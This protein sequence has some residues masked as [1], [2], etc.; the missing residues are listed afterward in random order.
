MSHRE[1]KRVIAGLFSGQNRIKNDA[2]FR[3][4]FVRTLADI[5]IETSHLRCTCFSHEAGI[6]REKN[7]RVYWRKAPTLKTKKKVNRFFSLLTTRHMRR[8]FRP[9]LTPLHG[10]M[11]EGVFHFL[12][13]GPFSTAAG[14]TATARI[15]QFRRNLQSRSSGR[16]LKI[17]ADRPGFL[18]Q[19]L[20]DHI[21][22]A[23][24]VKGQVSIPGLIQSNP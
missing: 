1:E 13:R 23:P 15:L 2:I 24:I 21:R 8:P 14:R 3:L 22:D 7:R 17:D 18:K 4:K 6:E 9:K 16:G 12:P 11:P 20:A 19:I 5:C 10:R